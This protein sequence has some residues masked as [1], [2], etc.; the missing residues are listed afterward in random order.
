MIRGALGQSLYKNYPHVYEN[1]MKVDRPNS[2]PNPFVISAPYPSK[3]SYAAGETLSFYVTLLG[4]A[5][6][7]E[8]NV[9]DAAAYMCEGKLS[10]TQLTGFE[11]IYNME[12]TD[13]GAAH[14]PMCEALRVNFIS[15]TEIFIQKQLA[16][17]LD[18]STFVDRVFL[19]IAGIIDSYGE[20][21]FV[22]PYHLI[23]AKPYIE[24]ACDFQV[25]KFQAGGQPITGF[26]GQVQYLGDVTRYLPYVDLCSQIHVGKKTT[27]ACGEYRF[28]I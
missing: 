21:E 5:Y 7:F 26:L 24:T 9:L 12:W 10:A 4:S 1:M 14:I 27:R 22:V 19:R 16:T 23:Y 17:Q 2:T 20:S 15:P 8:Q 28:E 6:V 18:F 11:Q 25:V 3:R 13:E